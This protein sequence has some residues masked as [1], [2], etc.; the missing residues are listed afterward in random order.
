VGRGGG[1]CCGAK[2]KTTRYSREKDEK[3][4]RGALTM[5]MYYERRVAGLDVT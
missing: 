3:R 4:G 2:H 1:A 5:I